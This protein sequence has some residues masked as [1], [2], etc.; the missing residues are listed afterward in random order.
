MNTRGSIATAIA[1]W[2][3]H[4]AAFARTNTNRIAL[5]SPNSA[6]QGAIDLLVTF[7]LETD[8]PPPPAGVLPGSVM[9]GNMTGTSVTHAAQ[10]TVTAHFNIPAG[11]A[12]GWKDATIVFPSPVGTL[13]FSLAQALQVAAG[14]DTETRTGL[15]TAIAVDTVG[16]GI[17]D[18]WR[19]KWYGGDG[20]STST[21]SA[22]G[23][24]PDHDGEDN[25]VEYQADTRPKDPLSRFRVEDVSIDT[26]VTV[27]FASSA[28]RRYT[29][30][31]TADLAS[32]L[33]TA[34]PSQTN[35]PGS[36]G[37]DAL[38]DPSPTGIERFYRVGVKP[39]EP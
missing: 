22:A 24:D 4:V 5:V 31:F 1:I 33:W 10:D 6:A 35:I 28:N 14:S 8:L 16:D 23:A 13:T 7:T 30:Y 18:W 32:G 2:L 20:R 17:P 21:D 25:H 29:L 9:L 12:V 27:R 37:T 26:G 19:A 11:E 15:V 36:G 34:I 39:P 3:T 38:S